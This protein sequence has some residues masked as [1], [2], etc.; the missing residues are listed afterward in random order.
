MGFHSSSTPSAFPIATLRAGGCF[1][2]FD[3]AYPADRLAFMFSDTDV[4]V[5]LTQRHLANALPKHSAKNIFLDE[6]KIGGDAT[7]FV[8]NYGS[9]F[10]HDLESGR[11]YGTIADFQNL[12]KLTYQSHYLHHSGG[13]VS[14]APITTASPPATR[15]PA[16]TT[17][18]LR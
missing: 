17:R 12:V 8:P 18:S 6:V 1:V 10:V 2:P 14:A 16:G 9:P 7:V 3:P 4:K 13:T 5:M 15:P 11:R